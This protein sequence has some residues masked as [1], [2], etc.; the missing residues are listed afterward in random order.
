MTTPIPTTDSASTTAPPDVLAIAV[1]DRLR[2]QE[3]LLAATRL[4]TRGSVQLSDAAMVGLN[5]RG[6]PHITQTHELSPGQG[7]MFGAWWGSLI[8]LF[9]F[10]LLGWLAGATAGAGLGWLRARRRDVGVPNE[11]MRSLAGRLYPGEVADVFQMRN[12]YPTHLIRELRR[13]DGR[14]LTDTIG[15]TD[16]ADIEDALTYAI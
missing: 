2:A 14:L 13:F 15:D 16:P 3:L 5:R 12:V 9:L 8:G 11:W 1:T 7:A 6:K 10:G 4:G